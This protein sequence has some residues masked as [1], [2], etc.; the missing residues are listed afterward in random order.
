MLPPSDSGRFAD[1][2][3]KARN[4]GC[5]ATLEA[6]QGHKSS[7]APA[8]VT[9]SRQLLYGSW[10]KKPSTCPGVASCDLNGG[11][12]LTGTNTTGGTDTFTGIGRGQDPP[13][14]SARP[15]P[16]RGTAAA[17]WHTATA[18]RARARCSPILA[19][20]PL[21]QHTASRAPRR[22]VRSDIEHWSPAQ[23]LA[24]PPSPCTRDRPVMSWMKEIL[25]L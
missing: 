22:A 13:S 7:Q 12:G 15:F 18:R 19:P 23:T 24:T 6:T 16:A 4:S 8:D 25:Q 10:I 11:P 3:N 14:L 2:S 20:R 17:G 9:V 5:G 21:A 1:G